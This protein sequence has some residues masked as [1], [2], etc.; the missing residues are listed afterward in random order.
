MDWDI[1]LLRGVATYR[2]GELLPPA[3]TRGDLSSPLEWRCAFGHE[4][5]GSPR[6]IL[7]GGHWCPDCITD[8]PGYRR[9][10]E[11]NAFLRQIETEPAGD[12]AP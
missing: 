4:F 8:V 9:Q 6:L 1:D 10:A 7:I 2:G 12:T 3:M 11:R 5:T